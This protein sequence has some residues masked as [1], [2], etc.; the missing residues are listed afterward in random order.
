MTRWLS[1]SLTHVTSSTKSHPTDLIVA[2]H[3]VL[4]PRPQ[5]GYI[6]LCYKNKLSHNITVG[7]NEIKYKVVIKEPEWIVITSGSERL[8]SVYSAE[9]T[10]WRTPF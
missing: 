6:T 1:P 2:K 9:A 5:N 7:Q 8:S 3:F 4:D 10:P